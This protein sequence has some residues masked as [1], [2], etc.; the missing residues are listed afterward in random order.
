[1]S[2]MG[3]LLD[4]SDPR[5]TIAE[6]RSDFAGII[7]GIE[8]LSVDQE[9]GPL[10]GPLFSRLHQGRV[11]KIEDGIVSGIVRNND[12]LTYQL[13]QTL[14]AFRL[15]VIVISHFAILLFTIT[16]L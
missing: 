12:P 9:T 16:H 1:M 8:A 11:L 4:L 14:G 7:S 6:S 3:V 13:A 10:G 5:M 15:Q 2:F